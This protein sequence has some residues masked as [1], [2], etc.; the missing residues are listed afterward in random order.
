M[1]A[2]IIDLSGNADEVEFVASSPNR[3]RKRTAIMEVLEIFPDAKESFVTQLLE[4]HDRNVAI[5]VQRMA[6]HPYE[7]KEIKNAN[8]WNEANKKI[9]YMTSSSFQPSDLYFRQVKPAILQRFRFLSHRDADKILRRANHHY[10]IAHDYV[11]KALIGGPTL[12]LQLQLDRVLSACNRGKAPQDRSTFPLSPLKKPRQ[13][14]ATMITDATLVQEMEYVAAKCEKWIDET[15]KQLDRQIQKHQAEASG[16]AVE[17]MCCCDT[18]EFSQMVSCT[19]GAHLFCEDCIN[20]YA[21]SQVFGSGNLGMDKKTKTPALAL[22]CCYGDCTATFDRTFLERALDRQTLQ[23]YD[24]IAFSMSVS[25][26]GVPIHRCPR[27]DFAAD[28]PESQ[29]VFSCLQCQFESCIECGQEAHIPFKCEEVEKDK[30]DT[31][32]RVTVEEAISA[33]LIRKCPSCKKPFVKT[34]GCNKMRCGCG[35]FSCYLCQRKIQGYDHFCQTAHCTHGQCGKCPLYSK[36]E[37]DLKKMRAAGV[38]A[39][40]EVGSTDINVDQMLKTT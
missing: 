39:A 32:Q 14:A 29:R 26:A 23:K 13:T 4:E 37:D 15:K 8:D 25:A 3:K 31:N 9:D 1:N 18:N 12:P 16:Q 6:E 11:W 19:E 22:Q 24:E 30:R 5:V 20:N 34:E 38:Q 35:A 40:T 36:P 28:V 17:C 33:A 2:E 27:C 10:A 7:K 21:K